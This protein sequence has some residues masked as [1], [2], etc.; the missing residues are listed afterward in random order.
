MVVYI[1]I[2]VFNII[3][4]FCL[5]IIWFALSRYSTHFCTYCIYSQGKTI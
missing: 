2:M 3:L 1:K 5:N 4:I